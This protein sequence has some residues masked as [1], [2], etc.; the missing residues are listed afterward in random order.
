[1]TIEQAQILMSEIRKQQ[2]QQHT[3]QTNKR[4]KSINKTL[5]KTK[6]RKQLFIMFYSFDRFFED[7]QLNNY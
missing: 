1:V 3:K 5:K 2:Q 6:V 4:F 7:I